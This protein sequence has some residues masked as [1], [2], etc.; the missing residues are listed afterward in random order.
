MLSNLAAACTATLFASATSD[1][2]ALASVAAGG[3]GKFRAGDARRSG[4]LHAIRRRSHDP[5]HRRLKPPIDILPLVHRM[6]RS[7]HSIVELRRQP[8]RDREIP[9]RLAQDLAARARLLIDDRDAD[10][11]LSK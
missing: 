10:A 3:Y 4:T 1:I 5:E 11:M 8:M 7:L 2:I 6:Q 9:R